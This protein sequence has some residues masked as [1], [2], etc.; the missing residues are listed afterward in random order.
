MAPGRRGA[1][2][3]AGSRGRETQGSSSSPFRGRASGRRATKNNEADSNTP[4]DDALPAVYRAMLSELGPES[5]SQ[6]GSTSQQHAVKRRRVGE[7]SRSR[8][9]DVFGSGSERE[10]GNGRET[11][12]RSV[13]N[14]Q[15]TRVQT[16]FD[17]D[18][19]DDD[20][21][22]MEW[23]DVAVQTAGPAYSGTSGIEMRDS[24]TD[25][26]LQ[27]TLGKGDAKGKRKAT[28]QKR[29]PVT[30]AEKG[31]RLDFHKAHVVCLLGHVAM[32]NRWCNDEDVHVCLS[33]NKINDCISLPT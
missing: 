8:A 14:V 28:A 27:I 30:G 22:C 11:V 6:S 23:E 19:S 12:A 21:E 9:V 32:R 18:A 33:L 7:R 2:S 1:R 24:S 25:E 20:D 16:V 26:P 10:A 31:M 3:K 15:D 5:Q 13:E 29:R 4:G 17:V